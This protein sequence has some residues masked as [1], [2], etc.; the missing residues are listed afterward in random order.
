MPLVIE[1]LKGKDGR[2]VNFIVSDFL[3]DSE[4]LE[5]DRLSFLGQEWIDKGT[6]YAYLANTSPFNYLQW[7]PNDVFRYEALFEKWVKNAKEYYSLN[8]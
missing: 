7:Q 6:T 1:I 4:A 3:D 8:F 2:N 5:F